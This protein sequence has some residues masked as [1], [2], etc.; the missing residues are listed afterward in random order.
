MSF[1]FDIW[2]IDCIEVFSGFVLVIYGDGVIGGVVN[3]I[4]KK[5]IC[6]KIENEIE[7]I[8]GIYYIWCFG[9]GSGGVIN[10]MFFYWVDIVGDCLD[11]WVDCGN[12]NNLSLFGVLCLDVNCDLFV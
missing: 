3:V 7:I 4:F 11:G 8:I 9:L 5:F 1:L 6:G 10:E 12:M 2:N